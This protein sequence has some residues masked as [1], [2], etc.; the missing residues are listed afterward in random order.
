MQLQMRISISLHKT[1]LTSKREKKKKVEGARLGASNAKWRA[2]S[3][4]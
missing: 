2:S 4:A 3:A 1:I